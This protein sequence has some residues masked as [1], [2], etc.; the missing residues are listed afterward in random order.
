[1]FNKLMQKEKDLLKEWNKRQKEQLHKNM[2]N[3][4]LIIEA[5]PIIIKIKK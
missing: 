5:N 2:V 3:R 1:M 4:Q